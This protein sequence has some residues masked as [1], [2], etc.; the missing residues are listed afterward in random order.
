MIAGA[1]N[2]EEVSI[3]IAVQAVM[4]MTMMRIIIETIGK[5]GMKRMMIMTTM[6]LLPDIR[7]R[8][9]MIMKTIMMTA[10]M[11]RMMIRTAEEVM[12]GITK[13]MMTD[14]AIAETKGI[15]TG[16]RQIEIIIAIQITIARETIADVPAIPAALVL[17]DRIQATMDEILLASAGTAR[18]IL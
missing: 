15:I 9:K 10:T 7:K 8:M 13:T 14:A 6:A 5:T 1:Q 11:M 18:D 12:E 16:R 4:K 17:Q 3:Q 2:K